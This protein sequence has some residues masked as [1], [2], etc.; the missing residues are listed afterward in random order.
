MFSRVEKTVVQAP[1]RTWPKPVWFGS[2]RAAH[3][4]APMLVRFEEHPSLRRLAAMLP[5]AA[6]G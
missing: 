4:M 1:F 3:R 2:H 5:W 6:W